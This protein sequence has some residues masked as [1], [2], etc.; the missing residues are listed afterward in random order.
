MKEHK[1]ENEA[2]IIN[3]L[4]AMLTERMAGLITYIPD[5]DDYDAI[6]ELTK[7]LSGHLPITQRMQLNR[8]KRNVAKI[9]EFK[10]KVPEQAKALFEKII[11]FTKH[12]KEEGISVKSVAMRRPLWRTL[13]KTLVS[14]VGLPFFIAAAF[15]T[16]P[17]WIVAWFI[18][19][20]LKDKAFRNT[21]NVCV[22]LILHPMIMATGVTLLFCLVP[23]K[24]ALLGS[25]FLYYSYVFYFDYS[26]YVRL[27]TSDWRWTFNKSLR[28]EF[29]ELN[30]F[31]RRKR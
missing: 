24:I 10:D 8:N 19:N 14:L 6:W 17:I 21:V 20:N 30:L 25:I 28:K 3:N 27:L 7:I 31:K 22:E 15:V 5:D 23:W 13:L 16:S 18:L 12:R 9:L 1:G 2:V 4:K 29:N 11:D 26:E